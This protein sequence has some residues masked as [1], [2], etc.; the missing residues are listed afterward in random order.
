MSVPTTS[1]LQDFAGH[2]IIV[3]GAGSGIG[4]ALAIQLSTRGAHVIVGDIANTAETVAEEISQTG[5]LA[6]AVV[7][8]ITDQSIVNSL[9]SQAVAQGGKLGLVNNAGVMDSFTGA[10]N[11]D[12]E[13]WDRCY[14]INVTAPF[15]LIRAVLP[16][17]REAGAGAIVNVGSAAS[18]RGAAAGAAYTASK[19][20]LV[21]LTKNTAYVYGRENIRTNLIAPGGVDTNIMDS[22][23]SGKINP[24]HGMGAMAPIHGSAVRSAES[25]EVAATVVFLLSD[26]ASD[27]NGVVLPVDAGWSAG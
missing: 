8:D 19:H 22:I 20:A 11:T 6:T 18:L 14:T 9:V 1:A 21:G 25:D 13:I 5:G 15:R 3:T 24:E 16:H 23:D 4:R 2:T 12:D 26:A 27:V 10:A 17:M 7:G